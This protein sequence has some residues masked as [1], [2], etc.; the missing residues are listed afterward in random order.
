MRILPT[1]VS[2]D[3]S[4][5]PS[6][7]F[8]KRAVYRSAPSRFEVVSIPPKKFGKLH[9]LG[10]QVYPI[11]GSD[12]VSTISGSTNSSY[13]IWR[14]WH[15]CLWFQ[16]QMETRYGAMSRMK[17]QRLQSGKGVKKNGIYIHDR[18]ASFESLPPGPDP[19]SVAKDLHKCLPKLTQRGTFF[20]ATQATVNQRQK[21][22]SAFVTALFAEDVPSLIKELRE[23]RVIRDFFG[24]WRRDYDLAV[25]NGSRR[26]KTAS[27]DSVRNLSSFLSTSGV[28]L[29]ST[30]RSDLSPTSPRSASLSQRSHIT[31]SS[32]SLPDADSV[33]SAA[34]KP[35]SSA[36]ARVCS[37]F[38]DSVTSGGEDTSVG[39]K[40]STSSFSNSYGPSPPSS[41]S[42][43]NTATTSKRALHNRSKSSPSPRSETF[44]VTSDFPLFLSS[45]TRDMLPT[46]RTPHSPSYATPGLGTL[47]EDSVLDSPV[48]NTPPPTLR[49]RTDFPVN[50]KRANR[51]V[52]IVPDADELSSEGDVLEGELLTPVD[53]ANFNV[54]VGR[55]TSC[56]SPT[57]SSAFSDLSI[58]SD[59]SS[60]RT[61]SEQTW[62][63]SAS[64]NDSESGIEIDFP[65]MASSCTDSFA[66]PEGSLSPPTASSSNSTLR[67][68]SYGHRRRSLSQPLPVGS[69]IP[70]DVGEEED[71]S[72][73]GEDLM[74]AYLGGSQS[75]FAPNVRDSLSNYDDVPSDFPDEALD[76]SSV[77]SF[78]TSRERIPSI[79][80]PPRVHHRP[81]LSG[82][83]SSLTRPPSSQ[84]S[85]TMS[86]AKDDTLIVKAVL[87]DAK[88]V[89]RV[90]HDVPLTELRQ[91]VLE[92]LSQTEGILPRGKFELSYLPPIVGG[93]GKN[94]MSTV[95][96]MM[97]TTSLAS[98]DWSGALPLRNESDWAT[99]IAS[100]GSKITL[101]VIYPTATPAPQ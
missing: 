80:G 43:H 64:S 28:S 78:S 67:S 65:H 68:S 33:L 22:L 98:V 82:T 39:R 19:K 27:F 16:D 10:L 34:Q 58:Q 12:S 24:Y 35:P 92:K 88:V 13:E 30:P 42:S 41:P 75:I 32:L 83:T 14:T 20:G 60:W 36:P 31:D 6:G 48:S 8:L 101:R 76:S 51:K 95:S 47:P 61:S 7:D 25:K 54:F 1:G 66:Q 89:L 79:Y 96:S 73:Q 50:T 17:I 77:I 29:F 69:S 21:E 55:S 15:D 81:H 56:S 99:A 86:I 100:C 38:R 26:P 87:D 94:R 11:T 62:P 45:S 93:A 59:G 72:D 97:S 85:R 44:N 2:E 70:T 9:Y 91:R 5:P 40:P 71:W 53:G 4:G 74:D 49:G 37:T 57:P 84:S 52:V 18:A 23:D 90:Q 63:S 3:D 46:S